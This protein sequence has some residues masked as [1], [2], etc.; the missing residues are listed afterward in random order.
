MYPTSIFACNLA[1]T[2]SNDLYPAIKSLPSIVEPIY[3]SDSNYVTF[4]TFIYSA[5]KR[6]IDRLNI[7]SYLSSN[8][9]LEVLDPSYQ[10]SIKIIDLVS[11]Q[12]YQ[13][14]TYSNCIP[15]MNIIEF[16]SLSLSAIGVQARK[17]VLGNMVNIL[18]YGF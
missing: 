15:M 6:Y 13:E 2:S 4:A 11:N 12:S 10:Y 17:G 18:S 3:V 14:M 5:S 8:N 1:V 16:G 9:D 7:Y